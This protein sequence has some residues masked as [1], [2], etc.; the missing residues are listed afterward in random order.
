M[1]LLPIYPLVQYAATLARSVAE[2]VAGSV[3]GIQ[4]PPGT[5]AETTGSHPAGTSGTVL[6]SSS[7]G[8]APNPA[9]GNPAAGNTTTWNT[10]T[11]DTTTGDTTAPNPAAANPAAANGADTLGTASPD[12][13]PF[14]SFGTADS[15]RTQPAAVWRDT[16]AQAVFGSRAETVPASRFTPSQAD[17]LTGNAV[18]Q[19]FVLLLA[20]TY[21]LLLHHNLRDVRALLGRITRDTASGKRLFDD[22]GSGGFSRFLNVATAIG[23]LFMGVVAVK[24]GDSLMPPSLVDMLPHG[25]VLAMSLLATAACVAVALFQLATVRLAGSVTLSQP[26][27]SQLVLLKRT[28]FSL[29][30]VVASPALLLF[31]LCPRGTGG[32]WFF[33][34]AA[35]LA[36]TAVLYLKETLALF[37]SK[38]ISI[39]HW[40]LY[41]CVVEI[42]PVSLLWL[43]AVR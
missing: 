16:T 12:A 14:G 11:G 32:V 34:V 27:V 39:L 13:L 4:N 15:V 22:T 17:S 9:A 25:A 8:T 18:F 28:Y 30:V 3:A 35:Q 29:A 19:G 7:A 6:E 38:K 31:A 26:F 21:A 2:P 20:A 24:Y 10:T 40:F 23:M 41:L 42:F 37:I 43:I 5:V 1:S 33:V 36:V